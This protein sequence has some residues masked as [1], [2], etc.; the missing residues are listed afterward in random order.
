MSSAAQ[1]RGF[2]TPTSVFEAPSGPIGRSGG[3][4]I[5]QREDCYFGVLGN[6]VWPMR[7]VDTSPK[8]TSS[9]TCPQKFIFIAIDDEDSGRRSI[10][11]EEDGELG[12][13]GHERINI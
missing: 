12:R 10:P 11:T 6:M 1:D 9:F 7:G 5:A 2:G 3:L 8:S 13:F 4:A